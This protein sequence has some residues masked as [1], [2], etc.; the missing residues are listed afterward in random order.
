MNLRFHLDHLDYGNNKKALQE[1]DKVLKKYPTIQS[2]RALKALVLMRLGR[3]DESTVIVEKLAA[4]KPTDISTLQAMT[5]CYKDQ[6][7][8][9]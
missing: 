4:E 2:A 8:C 3:E 1:A 9:K 7:E 6:E 5:Y